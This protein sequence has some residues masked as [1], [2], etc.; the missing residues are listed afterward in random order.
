MA[1]PSE[2]EGKHMDA[3]DRVEE[4]EKSDGSSHGGLDNSNVC[5]LLQYTLDLN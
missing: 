1:Q 3:M 4:G 5:N 2:L